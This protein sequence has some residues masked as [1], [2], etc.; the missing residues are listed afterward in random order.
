MAEA[1]YLN[2]KT[3][4]TQDDV[5]RLFRYDPKTGHL[6]WRE[7][8]FAYHAHT[9]AGHSH[10]KGYRQVSIN[11]KEY[12]VHRIIWLLV[13]GCHPPEIDHINGCRDDNRLENLRAVDRS[14]NQHNA[15]IRKDNTSGCKGVDFRRRTGRW[16]ARL[17]LQG[18][19]KF[20]GSFD[21]LD[22]AVAARREAA[23]LYGV[24]T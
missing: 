3:D 11:S 14:G 10:N 2:T 4:L 18:S 23:K 6:Y 12:L 1:N 7:P 21:S 20:I 8:R 17:Q 16:V 9:P 22:D 15:A 24:C 5:A 13:H 19:R